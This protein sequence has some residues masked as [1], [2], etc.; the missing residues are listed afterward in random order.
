MVRA[1]HPESVLA[2]ITLPRRIAP[3]AQPI[4]SVVIVQHVC[5]PSFARHKYVRKSMLQIVWPQIHAM[6]MVSATLQAFV[7]VTNTLPVQTARAAYLII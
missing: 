3:F 5:E 4:I 6:T 2:T 7:L 1:T